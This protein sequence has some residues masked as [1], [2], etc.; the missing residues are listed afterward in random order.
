MKKLTRLVM[1]LAVVAGAFGSGI[2]AAAPAAAASGD[3]PSGATC[4]WGNTG[5]T[6]TS[7]GCKGGGDWVGFYQY[8]SN[9][10]SYYF[11]TKP[12]GAYTSANDHVASVFNRGTQCNSALYADAGYG[13]LAVK[14]TRGTGWTNLAGS[15][16]RTDLS[17]GQFTC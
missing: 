12:S 3:C 8:I 13:T 6:T 16:K 17:S 5:Y 11:C 14:I 1:G 7:Y 2:V 4:V 9:F 10:Q 15:G